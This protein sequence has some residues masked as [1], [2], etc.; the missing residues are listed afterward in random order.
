MRYR[1]RKPR[2]V[3]EDAAK[4]VRLSERDIVSLARKTGLCKTRDLPCGRGKML[5]APAAL[6]AA[7]GDEGLAVGHVVHYAAGLGVAHER[8]AGNADIKALAVLARAALA[9]TVRAR[10]GDV[11]TLVS[12]VHQRGHIVIDN[13]NDISAL[14][15]VA[16]VGTAC[17]DVF[18]AVERDGSVAAVSGLYRYP[19]LVNK[20]GSHISPHYNICF[21]L[22]SVMQAIQEHFRLKRTVKIRR[23]VRMAE[24]YN[25][26]RT[27][28]S[29]GIV[30]LIY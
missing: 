6:A 11:F 20:R 12:E 26:C 15:A 13:E 5:V 24:P 14:A 23:A 19:C 18:L 4:L 28:A 30:M 17:R 1:A 7:C 10:S 29:S 9:L 27:K 22:G 2:A 8:T 3:L 25:K 21:Y 16:A